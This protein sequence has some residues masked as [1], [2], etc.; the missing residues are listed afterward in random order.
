MRKLQLA[1]TALL[2]VVLAVVGFLA[3][4]L[5]Q[6]DSFREAIY[7]GVS[8]A[9]VPLAGQTREQAIQTLDE[10]VVAPLSQPIALQY[11]TDTV[12]LLPGD[13]NFE[14]F[15]DEMVE[16]AYALG[17]GEQAQFWDGYLKFLT[18]GLQPVNEDLPLLYAYD[19]SLLEDF[20]RDVAQDKDQPL[21]EVQ[22]ITD[23]L[24]FRPGRRGRK[25]DIPSSLPLVEQSLTSPD[26]RE[27]AL[28]VDVLEPAPP[29]LEMLRGVVQHRIDEFAGMV[30][31]YISNPATDE[32]MEINPQISYSGMS[33]VKVGIMLETFLHSEGTELDEET[34]EFMVKVVTDPTGSNYWANLLLGIIGDGSQMEGSRRVNARMDELGLT[35]TFIREPYRLETEGSHRGPGHAKLPLLQGPITA[36]PDPFIQTSAHDIGV[37][38]EMI[39]D[40]SQGEGRLLEEYEGRISS[41]SC[42][43]ILDDLKQNPVRTMIGAGIPEDVP[44]AHKHG[45]AY[46]THADAGIVFLEDT[47]YILVHFQYAPTDWLVWALSVPVFEDVSYATY[48]FFSL[49]VE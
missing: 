9:G 34:Q 36:N 22:P 18:E 19:P 49:D 16:E 45:F 1:I 6:Y 26:K 43:L 2:L 8:A 5:R 46:D 7:P 32:R 31:I 42:Q 38:L 35:A 47:D 39:Y 27:V 29:D 11:V 21:R 30:S 12:V 23:T 48:N 44:L 33:V 25:L 41:E 40:C 37:L 14:I 24:S 20:L 13:V 28:V 4:K 17:R 15:L 10:V 3:Y